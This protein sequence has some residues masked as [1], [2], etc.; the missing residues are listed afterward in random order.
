VRSGRLAMTAVVGV[1]LASVPAAA[2]GA[3]SAAAATAPAASHPAAKHPAAS[4]PAAKHP[5]AKHPAAK[6]PAAKKPVPVVAGPAGLPLQ[7]RK[8]AGVRISADSVLGQIGV[9]AAWSVTRGAGVLVAV[10]DTGVAAGVPDLAGTVTTGPD[11]IAET[12]PKHYRPPDS[13]GTYI[14]SLIAAHGSG[15]KDAAGVIGVAP[16]A[17]I[18]SLRVIPDDGEPSRAAVPDSALASAI[19]Y[20]VAHGA[21]VI[22]LPLGTG[23]SEDVQYAAVAYAI[24]HGVVVVA[25]AGDAGTA[26]ATSAPQEYPA[27]YPGVIAVAAATPAGTRAP[28]SSPNQSVVVAAPGEDISGA[29]PGGKYLQ[30][31]GTPQAA[32]LVAGVAALIRARYPALSPALVEQALVASTQHG[33]PGGYDTATG[34]GE[35]DAATALAAAAKLADTVPA[36]VQPP[37][38]RF[39]AGAAAL[40][41]DRPSASAWEALL[42]V[43]ALVFLVAV[44]LGLRLL[45][46][47]R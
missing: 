45:R 29:G 33:P 17:R 11:F 42:G 23:Q 3:A 7:V 43:C 30:G 18:L 38:Q 20:A 28:F 21:G 1:F 36:P 6:H 26:R 5:A 16:A 31:D 14:A 24:S 13:H 25:P 40:V 4:H 35:V 41:A 2:M 15:K 37:G 32:A 46:G 39:S 34:F 10:L 9:P 12:E 27:A 47:R 22:V 44:G 8:A 19:H